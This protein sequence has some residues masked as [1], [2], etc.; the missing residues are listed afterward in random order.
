MLDLSEKI[1]KG[2]PFWSRSSN[3]LRIR[4]REWLVGGW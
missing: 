1:K 2:K 3:L 4:G